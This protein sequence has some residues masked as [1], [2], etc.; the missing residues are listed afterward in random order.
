[1]AIGIVVTA[2]TARSAQPAPCRASWLSLSP[3][4]RPK[5]APRTMRVPTIN[6]ISGIVNVRSL[7]S[8]SG[9]GGRRSCN[10]R[11]R[12]V[13]ARRPPQGGRLVRAGPGVLRKSRL[14]RY[15][16][17][18]PDAAMPLRGTGNAAPI[19]QRFR[20]LNTLITPAGPFGT[21]S[22]TMPRDSEESPLLSAALATFTETTDR[23]F[24][25]PARNGSGPASAP[26]GAFVRP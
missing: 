23:P 17:S 8:H 1:M 13:A 12:A 6:M 2:P 7:T 26:S 18:S 15:S 11:T 20:G 16:V 10:C 21:V 19:T 9:R 3:I 4:S 24:G 14:R 5:P 25:R 22:G